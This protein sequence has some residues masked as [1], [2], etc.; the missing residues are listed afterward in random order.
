[1]YDGNDPNATYEDAFKLRKA[2]VNARR[3]DVMYEALMACKEMNVTV[4]GA[5][6]EADHIPTGLNTGGD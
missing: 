6:F 2:T 5:P 4:V 1:M 3:N